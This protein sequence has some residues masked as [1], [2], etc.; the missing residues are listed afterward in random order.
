VCLLLSSIISFAQKVVTGKVTGADG[1]PASGA[2]VTVTGTTVGTQT[3]AEGNFSITVPQGKNS[4]TVSYIGFENQTV[5]LT[6]QSTV[7]VPLRVSTSSLSEVI[8]TGYSGQQRRNI[9]GAVSTVKGEQLAAVPSGNAE[10][11]FQ[12]RVPGVTVI[13]SGQPGTV[14]QVRIRGFG[15]FFNNNPL[16][17][18]DGIPTTNIDFLNPNDVESSTVLKDAGSASIYGARAAAGVII[19][20]TKKAKYGSKLRVTYDMSYG[21]TFPGKGIKL[22]TPQQQADLTWEALKAAG[23]TLTHPQYGSGPTPI[24][25]DYLKVGNDAGLSGL[26]PTDPRLDPAKFNTDFDKGPIYQVIRANKQGTDWYKALTTRGY[27]QNHTIGFN[28]GSENARYYAGISVYDEKGVVI[29]TN[30]KRY[31]L[32]FNNEFKIKNVVRIGSNFQY[33]YRDNPTIGGANQENSILFALTINP[34]IPV[35]DEGGGF[36]GTTARGFNNST[37]PVAQRIRSREN[38]GFA[39]SIFGNIYAEAD[40]LPHLTARTSFGGSIGQFQNRFLNYR[41]YENSENVG[42]YTFGEGAGYGQGYTWTNTVRY[43]NEFGKHS[44]QALAGVEAVKDGFF[45]SLS[46]SGLNPFSTNF[47]FTTLTNTD[48]N[49][50]NLNSGGNPYRKLFSQFGQVNYNYNNKYLFSATL[51]RDGSS[52]FGEANKYGIFPAISA[53]WRISQEEFMRSIPWITELK[54]RG[55]Y[56]IMGNERPIGSANRFNTIGGTP[57]STGYDIS[58]SNT[59][60]ASGIRVTGVGATDV[61]WETNA[62]SNIGFDGTFFKNKLEV[63]FDIYQR[64]TADLLFNAALPATLGEVNAPFVNIGSMENRGVDLMITY[65]GRTNKTFRFETDFIFTTYKNTITKVSETADYFDVGFSGRIGGGFVRNAVGQPVSSFFGY[66][67]LGLFQDANDVAKS[68]TQAGAGPGRFKYQDVNADGK[69]DDNDRTYIGNPNP[70]FTYGFNTRLI[71]KGF[72]LEALFYGVANAKVLNFTKWFT[73]FYP[74][75]AGIGKSERVLNAWT[76]T[77]TNATIP[78][79]ENVSN[80]S[81]NANLNSYYVENSAYLRLRSVKLGFNLPTGTIEKI[82]LD[83]LHVFLQATNLFTATKYT[84]L[85]PAVSGADTNFGVD[86]GNYPVNKQIIFGFNVGL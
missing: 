55:G 13:T 28:G 29:N 67:V 15:S 75:F 58:G 9:V 70:A 37:N 5:A 49:G 77:N 2:T 41:T 73:D 63:I 50:R 30:L 19:M 7:S 80:F 32:R 74:S 8:V 6:G 21:L 24:L 10:Q 31:S 47:N 38:R 44:I 1:Q 42:S 4:L 66:N 23:Q 83:R 45:R 40:L 25:P 39:S 14:S 12:G 62:T 68:P 46:G 78:R 86:V 65:R 82:G 64:K 59:S 43:E 11:Q 69:I 48:P 27:V 26:S 20:T 3:D 17:I 51:R 79:F 52:V 36:A 56:G 81:T 54:I 71:Y 16:Y 34:L 61:K 85:D 18:V 72:D 60:V 35:Y 53:G 33:T 22:L 76:P 84:G 57:G